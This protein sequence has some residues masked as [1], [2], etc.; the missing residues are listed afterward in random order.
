MNLLN[1]QEYRPIDKESKIIKWTLTNSSNEE[2]AQRILPAFCFD[3]IITVN[4]YLIVDE[5][6]TISPFVSPILL[7]SKIVT[8]GDK[9]K[10]KGY[11]FNPVY[12]KEITNINPQKLKQRANA[13]STLLDKEKAEFLLNE[14]STIELGGNS[15]FDFHKEGNEIN[16]IKNAVEL[17][18]KDPYLP[19]SKIA[20]SIDV[21]ERWLQKLFKEYFN[22][23][24]ADL[25]KLV[26]FSNSIIS[27]STS[28]GNKLSAVANDNHYFD[29]SH[30]IKSFKT[31]S[32]LL[33]SQFAKLNNDFFSVMNS[34]Q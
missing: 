14:L 20:K 4:G 12:F 10:I 24:P 1:I 9:T 28:K 31:L 5:E 27:I 25:K 17:I 3:L 8:I 19:V 33:P 11:R 32:G 22:I 21:S 26:K 34:L 13:L 23:S 29:Q 6:K 7:N 15:K 16:F 2:I 30:F 18:I